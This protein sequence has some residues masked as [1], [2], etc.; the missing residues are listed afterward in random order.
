MLISTRVLVL[1]ALLVTP[2]LSATARIER[3][4]EK[5][6]TVSGAGTVRLQTSGGLLRVTPG[7]GSVVTVTAVQKIKADSESE[8][9]DLLAKLELTIVQSGNDVAATAKYESRPPGFRFGS[10]PPVN[11]DFIV[12]VPAS[13]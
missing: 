4:V 2:F 10:W 9:D 13:F 5:S 3:K 8:A 11:V 12:T 1:G 6:F 7:D